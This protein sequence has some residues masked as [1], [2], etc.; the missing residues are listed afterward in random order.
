MRIMKEK[1]Q[2]FHTSSKPPPNKEPT[3]NVLRKSGFDTAKY[4]YYFTEVWK[5]RI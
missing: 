2:E 4:Y 5:D 3:P 1:P